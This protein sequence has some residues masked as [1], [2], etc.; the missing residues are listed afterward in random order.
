MA[1]VGSGG[2]LELCYRLVGN[3]GV[4][5]ND[6]LIIDF[7][8]KIIVLKGAPRGSIQTNLISSRLI[9]FNAPVPCSS[10]ASAR[11]DQISF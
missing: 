7:L 2:R 1:V 5:D 11:W 4:G 9:T 3:L 6:L 10:E 8:G